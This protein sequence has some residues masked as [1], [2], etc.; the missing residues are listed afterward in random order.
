[1]RFLFVSSLLLLLAGCS[2]RDVRVEFPEG[3]PPDEQ[4]SIGTS[5]RI[6]DFFVWHCL[7][8]ERVAVIRKELE[9]SCAAPRRETTACGG[10]TES[11][12]AFANEPHG[13]ARTVNTGP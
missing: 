1:M 6:V 10:L 11:E 12:K 3:V 4:Y 8:G 5:P 13:P 9:M 7:K 2:C